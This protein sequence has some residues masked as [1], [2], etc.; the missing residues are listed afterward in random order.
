MSVEGYVVA[1][2]VVVLAVIGG[3][4]LA[5][6]LRVPDAIVLVALGMVLGVLPWPRAVSVSPEVVLLVFL[7]P[8]IYNAAFFSSPRDMRLQGRPIVVMAVGTTLL[9]A[10]GLAGIVY[11][12]M[13]E[14]SWP[15]AIALGA[16]I[17]PTDAVAASAILKRVGT[18]RRVL[19]ILEG[20]SLINDGVAL[21]LFTL[22]VTAMAHP[23]TVTGG[24]VEL[25][26]VVAG[27]LAYGAVVALAV[28][29]SRTRMQDPSLLLMVTLI[30]PFVAYVPA[31][32]AGFSGVLA[33]VVAGFYL[34]TR[35]E[36]LLPPRVR[37]NGRTIWRV[38]VSLLESS[39]FV[40]LGLQ[41]DAVV[42]SVEAHTYSFLL[43]V[44]VAVAVTAAAV[45][46]RMVLVVA[47]AP[48]QRSIPG[49]RVD[50]GN[51]RERTVIG[52]SGMRGAVSLAIALS[53]PTA[54]GGEP[55]TERGALVFVAGVVVLGTLVGQGMTL[56]ALLRRLG[57]VSEGAHDREYL[58]AEVE[59][60]AAALREVEELLSSGDIDQESADSL[61]SAYARRLDHSRTLMDGGDA[62]RERWEGR[63]AAHHRITQARRDAL[64][65]LYR[66]GRIDHD[67][68]QSVG[69]ALDLGDGGAGPNG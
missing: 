19:T 52:W 56:P 4:L 23:L 46:L 33:A 25:V 30:T 26:K 11:W 2:L 39:L 10:F 57:M 60:D 14:V 51:V 1:G 50:L 43:L 54:L 21:T 8:L 32:M 16:A 17:A 58:T 40:L 12:L 27:G 20:E 55:F 18:P 13:P 53:L 42:A 31:E 29:W 59:M 36:G 7:P 38:L 61:R 34:G 9:T 28:S 64:E 67:V 41:L 49:V 35:G 45:L 6:R 44:G 68:F 69:K 37:V 22:A 63:L 5:G 48:V 15:A 24:A 66:E 65:S 62:A 3:R 47:V